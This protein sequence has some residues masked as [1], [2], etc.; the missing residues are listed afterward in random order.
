MNK[1]LV[2]Y[3]FLRSASNRRQS[4]SSSVSTGCE[5]C[6]RL[7]LKAGT[8][9]SASTSA[10]CVIVTP[11]S[12][13]PKP[14]KRGCK[15]SWRIRIVADRRRGRVPCVCGSCVCRVRIVC[16]PCAR[17]E[18][19]TV[20]RQHGL[21]LAHERAGAEE[22][23]AGADIAV[24]REDERVGVLAHRH[25]DHDRV[26]A[27]DDLHRHENRRHLQA[28]RPPQACQPPS[29]H[30]ARLLL[31][32][33]QHPSVKLGRAHSGPPL[34]RPSPAGALYWQVLPRLPSLVRLFFAR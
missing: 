13:T 27:K 34:W 4:A 31:V 9:C 17:R 6:M 25:L 5:G 28:L 7:A 14:K 1:R 26:A 22:H 20:A 12:P 16:V 24:E 15:K 2:T 10:V 33:E 18:E 29:S 21:A 3:Y 32:G 8:Y 19:H 11:H 23:D 30:P